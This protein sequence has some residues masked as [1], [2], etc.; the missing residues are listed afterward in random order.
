[1]TMMFQ[2][3]KTMKEGNK[4]MKEENTKMMQAIKTLIKK[5]TVKNQELETLKKQIHD[6]QQDSRQV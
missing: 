2:D 4:A 3:H 5:E 6:L 1:M